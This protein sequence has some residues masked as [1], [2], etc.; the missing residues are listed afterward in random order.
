MAQQVFIAREKQL[1][2]LNQRL[3]QA[4][5]GQGQ[6]CFVSGE[7]GSGKTTLVNEFARRAQE[8]NKDLVVA[9]GQCG[10]QA[11]IGDAHLPFRQVMAQLTG[12]VEVK[13]AQGAI[14]EEN[15]SRLRKML[16]LSGQA[17]V[18]VG[19]DLI[20]IFVPG[21]GLVTRLGAF[22][23]E[24]V[25][26]LDKLERLSARPK[27]SLGESGLQESHIFEQYA[28]VL[29]RLAQKH[30]LLLVLDD[31]HWA[32]AASTA[33]LFH[34][35][36]RIAEHKILILGTFRGA[37][38]AIGRAG[39]RH[40]LE[41]V[42]AEFKRYFGEI[43]ID[44]DQAVGQE[45]QLF[46]DAFLNSEPNA[47]G[48]SFSDRLYRHTGG[49]PLFT[50]E[51]LRNMQERGDLLRDEQ[52]R[53][54]PGASLDWEDLP[55]RVEGVIEERIGRL[56]D[57]LRQVLT[58]GSVQGEDF[59]AEVIARVRQ[60]DAGG[61]IRRLSSE[62]D[63][64]H[65]LIHAEGIRRLDPGGQRI[66]LFRF[67]H[68]LFRTYLY[69]ELSEAERAYLHEDVGNAIEAL[70]GE[71]ADEMAVQ[72]ALHFETA[73]VTEK[74]RH[75]LQKAGEQATSRFANDEALDFF[76]RALDLTPDNE[77]EKRYELLLLREKVLTLKGA[78]QEQADD[79]KELQRLAT[80]L[81]D[82]HKKAKVALQLSSFA[83]ATGDYPAAI[84]SAQ[85]AV[86]LADAV[87]D[88]K[89]LAQAHIT[90]G[91]AARLIADYATA[92]THYQQALAVSRAAKLR[93]EESA[94]LRALGILAQDQSDFSN[95]GNLY[96][97]S[98][99]ISQQDDDRL[100]S[101]KTLITLGNL[102]Y[103]QDELAKAKTYYEEV[104][105]IARKTGDQPVE[106]IVLGNLGMVSADQGHLQEGLHFFKQALKISRK[107]ADPNEEGRLL[108]SLG[109][110]SARMGDLPAATA[111]A[112]EALD[113]ARQHSLKMLEAAI[114]N[115]LGK[116]L[117]QQ[118]QYSDASEALQNSLG[119]AGDLK[120]RQWEINAMINL[121]RLQD[122]IGN[123]Q[124]A[125]DYLEQAEESS[126]VWLPR[127]LLYHHLDQ[128][129][130]AVRC[131]LK[132]I[133]QAKQ[134]GSQEE[135]ACALLY[136]GN[137]LARLGQL[138]GARAAYK[139][140]IAIRQAMEQGFKVTESQAGLARIALQENKKREA[141]F[142]VTQILDFLEERTLD[143]TDEPMR[144]YL[145]CYQV[146]QANRDPRADVVLRAAHTLLM[147]HAQ[148]IEDEAMRQSYLENVAANRE[149]LQ[150]FAEQE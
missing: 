121:G 19:P 74:A 102:S 9:V 15:A 59:T 136:Y 116:M 42:L 51:L 32:D 23:A 62:L 39:E 12:D 57:E 60:A 145:T 98:L 128:D 146:L 122:C 105:P 36:R 47:L 76:N 24:K 94:S 18:D 109:Y 40:P 143:G 22:V 114:L 115:S 83:N 79:L 68:N 120:A 3:A 70:Y 138:E 113:L 1:E 101:N 126:E 73:G 118:A 127:A 95:A 142:L 117:T 148:K 16:V 28:N 81:D 2:Q 63:R 92:R 91:N 134:D 38:V 96:E 84:Q 104:L 21:V 65:R 80:L 129:D 4:A 97:E 140:S 44:L 150:S 48:A 132:A 25:G 141:F 55:T 6:V 54:M 67:Q 90:W 106:G 45:G 130:E 139:Q 5:A 124:G 133:Q 26:W 37:E 93:R 71:Q 43:L 77:S 72:L 103:M 137:A 147:A 64:Q 31:L 131:C 69:H 112:G 107:V 56:Q 82:D 46:V 123:Y 10:A 100:G 35:C 53:W 20:G 144:V 88:P 58:V 27:V 41:K 86:Q 29:C 33:L 135:E 14:T 125:Q 49:H 87:R 119:I 108:Y 110:L 11:G 149:I 99:Q 8:Q 61:L 89:I 13:L 75:Y 52:G 30:P 66:S 7:A 78:R 50:I 17:L 34:L 111:Y 85:E